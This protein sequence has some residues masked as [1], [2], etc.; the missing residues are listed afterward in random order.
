[1]SISETSIR[2]RKLDLTKHYQSGKLDENLYS[3]ALLYP[4]IKE[5]DFE[6]G[7]TVFKGL[8]KKSQTKQG[9]ICLLSYENRAGI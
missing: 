6:G 3:G 5:I 7:K 8:I 4:E 2:K 9:S 1:M